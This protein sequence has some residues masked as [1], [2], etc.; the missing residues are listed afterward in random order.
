MKRSYSSDVNSYNNNNKNPK[1]N[2]NYSLKGL[3]RVNKKMKPSVL[4]GLIG[5]YSDSSEDNDD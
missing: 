1:S 3:V 2:T 5:N 4:S